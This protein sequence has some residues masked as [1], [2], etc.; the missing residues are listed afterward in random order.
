MLNHRTIFFASG[1][2]TSKGG[3]KIGA[4]VP[5]SIKPSGADFVLGESTR[6]MTSTSI[7]VCY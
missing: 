6:L 2:N 3:N 5:N 7:L 1:I 4:L